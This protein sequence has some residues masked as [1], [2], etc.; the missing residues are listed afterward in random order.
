MRS[1]P[2]LRYVVS[3]LS[4]YFSELTE[5]Q[6]T[7][8]KHV[9]KYLKGTNDKMLC[10]RKCD[11]AIVQLLEHL[12]AYRYGVPMIRQLSYNCIGKESR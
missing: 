6:W 1:T 11:E 2:D 7:T 12:D 5:E 10:Y 9:L 4:Q 8:A 3:K